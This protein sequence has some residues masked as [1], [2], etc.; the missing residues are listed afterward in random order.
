MYRNFKF[1]FQFDIEFEKIS[2]LCSVTEENLAR[3][4]MSIS[5]NP[6]FWVMM[7][8]HVPQD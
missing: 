2:T 4:G 6:P 1:S 3:V 8:R 5:M 7:Q